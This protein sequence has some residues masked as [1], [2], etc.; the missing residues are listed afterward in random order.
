MKS[1][2]MQS[3]LKQS[4]LE[5][6]ILEQ[7]SAQGSAESHLRF[8]HHWVFLRPGRRRPTTC[9]SC[10]IFTADTSSE[11]LLV[12]INN[13]HQ[14]HSCFDLFGFYNDYEMKNI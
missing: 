7:S 9:V 6:S 5:Q 8:P 4:R 13:S 10:S 14:L 3:I 11:V 1:R 12:D 2:I